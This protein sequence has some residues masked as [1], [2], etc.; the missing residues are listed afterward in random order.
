MMA[1]VPSLG[2]GRNGQ[3]IEF[4]CHVLGELL[5]GCVYEPGL[6]A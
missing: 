6:L 3:K 5:Q 4:E 2:N 1:T